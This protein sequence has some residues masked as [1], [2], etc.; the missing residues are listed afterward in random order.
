ML[1]RRGRQRFTVDA[2]TQLINDL[3]TGLYPWQTGNDLEEVNLS[4][5]GKRS[6]LSTSGG[7]ESGGENTSLCQRRKIFLLLPPKWLQ[8]LIVETFY[9]AEEAVL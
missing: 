5:A 3:E 7:V 2:N 6:S 4:F 9:S 8:L 1:R